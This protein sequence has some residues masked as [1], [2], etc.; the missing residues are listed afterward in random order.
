VVHDFMTDHQPHPYEQ[1]LYD[2]IPEDNPT[3]GTLWIS[4]R[5]SMIVWSLVLELKF[6]VSTIR[7]CVRR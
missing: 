4:R 5:V 2:G 1:D 7:T 3:M 6:N